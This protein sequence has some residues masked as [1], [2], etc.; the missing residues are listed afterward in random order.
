M[1]SAAERGI[2]QV[3]LVSFMS[4][5]RGV[6]VPHDCRRLRVFEMDLSMVFLGKWHNYVR[7]ASIRS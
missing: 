7:P 4:V 5:S 3:R 1:T 6:G 2:S